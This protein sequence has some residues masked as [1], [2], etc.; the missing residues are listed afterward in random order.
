MSDL[1]ARVSAFRAAFLRHQAAE[2][3]EFAGAFA[4]RHPGFPRSQEHNQL[5]VDAP[6]ADPESLVAFA[7]QG[8]G[9]RRDHRIQVLDETVGERAAPVLAAAG[10]GR[11]AELV[12]VRETAGCVRP[13]PAARP[14]RVDELREAE[15]A[16]LLRW[17]PDQELARQLHERR[18]A[19]LHGAAAEGRA[20]VLFLAVREP[21]GEVAAWV[22]L[23]LDRAAGLAELTDLVT[24]EPYRGRGHGD[25]LVATGLALAA[26]A[27]IPRLFLAADDEDWP[28]AWYAR[29][30]FRPIG[31]S[32]AF[33]RMSGPT[34]A[35]SD[36]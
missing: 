27:G 11:A 33:L 1:L 17:W 9:D 32:Y 31:H 28:K 26:E 4:V 29:R 7:E 6:G 34:G 18:A 21:D 15:L 24:A 36:S 12:M 13:D 23:Y 22:D 20:E 16:Q 8:V 10:F 5:V 14:V 30:G 25:T 3:V 19:R 35:I 2:T